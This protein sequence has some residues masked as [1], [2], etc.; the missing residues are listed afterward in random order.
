MSRTSLKSGFAGAAGLY[1][2]GSSLVAHA[3]NTPDPLPFT[4]VITIGSTALINDDVRSNTDGS[5]TLLGEQQGG[6]FNGAP[7]W[8][9]SWDLTIKQDPFING[10]LTLTN[11]TTTTRNFSFALSLPVTP[12]FSP[13]LFGGSISAT[14]VDANGDL[15]A[16]LAPTS[17]NPSVYRGTIDGITVLSLFAMNLGCSGSSAGCTASI[18]DSDGLPGPT[19]AGP[20]VNSAIGTLLTFSLSA[21]DR[22]TFATN[23]TVEP[24]SPVPLPAALP[25]L[26]SGVGVFALKRRLLS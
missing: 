13:S 23:F 4:P 19:L 1:F 8:E 17:A 20:A 15:S 6:L 11:L 16:S 9:L 5:Y 24:P 18:G 26:L 12:A 7:I 2:I 25:L 21:G 3:Q 22:V 14:L 10:S